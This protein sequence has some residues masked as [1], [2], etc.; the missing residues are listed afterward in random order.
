VT[1]IKD[2]LENNLATY[3]ATIKLFKFNDD[4]KH[5]SDVDGIV[6]GVIRASD[7][8]DLE[9]I[10][11]NNLETIEGNLFINFLTGLKEIN[12]KNIKLINKT[13]EVYGCHRLEKIIFNSP[14]S[15]KDELSIV[16]N[17]K[18][19]VIDLSRINNVFSIRITHNRHV[20]A[21]K[22]GHFSCDE[23]ELL[24]MNSLNTISFISFKCNAF[25]CDRNML[26]KKIVYS[27]HAKIIEGLYEQTVNE[28]RVIVKGPFDL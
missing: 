11:F 17:N 19:N 22:F 7:Y 27:G 14:I 21:I 2:L 3:D 26:N 15:I 25:T 24:S 9:T 1:G 23:L 4:I 16:E 18:L 8:T 28:T 12:L 5:I 10:D 13:F 20:K 6:L